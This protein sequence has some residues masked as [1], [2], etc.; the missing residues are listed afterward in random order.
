MVTIGVGTKLVFQH[1]AL[2]VGRLANLQNT[3]L[4]H[5]RSPDQLASCLNVLRILQCGA[6]VPDDVS[7]GG[8]IDLVREV[9]FPGKSHV[10]LHAVREGIEGSGY[11]LFHRHSH[12]IGGIQ[13]CEAIEC[14][15][16]S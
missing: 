16:E 15:P 8:F 6:D 1:V 14:A 3:V 12:G 11:D 4:R 13:D 2:E 5:T 10:S 7:L 9:H